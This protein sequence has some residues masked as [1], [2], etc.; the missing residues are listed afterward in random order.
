MKTNYTIYIE[1]EVMDRLREA[2][3]AD[4]R[5]L[6]AQIEQIIEEYLKTIDNGK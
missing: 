5:T 1:S 3:K 6:S 4:K 2:A